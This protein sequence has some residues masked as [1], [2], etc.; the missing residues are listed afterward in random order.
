MDVLTHETPEQY[1]KKLATYL[2]PKKIRMHVMMEYGRCP[3]MD[4]LEKWR[5]SYRPKRPKV[6]KH[7]DPMA[8]IA[9]YVV[10]AVAKMFGLHP[11]SIS[12]RG[13]RSIA[14]INARSVI[15]KI[16]LD[17]GIPQSKA[18]KYVGRDNTSARI[19]LERFDR[20][21]HHNDDMMN[22]YRK[23]LASVKS[24]AKAS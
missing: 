13:D 17:I 6:I 16:L 8:G 5:S 21:A 7:D 11:A 10:N 19:S 23:V 1:A 12:T 2:E 22:A 15:I 4:K 3:P 24:D 20:I 9:T 18:G 14:S